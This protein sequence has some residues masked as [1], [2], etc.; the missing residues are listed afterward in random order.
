MFPI[1]AVIEDMKG[2]YKILEAQQLGAEEKYRV[3]ILAQK[4]PIFQHI[5]ITDPTKIKWLIIS[6]QNLSTIKRIS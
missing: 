6:S 5:P 4:I 1:G 3:Q 2:T